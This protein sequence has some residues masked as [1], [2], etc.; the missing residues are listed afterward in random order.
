MTTPESQSEK[1]FNWVATGAIAGLV[2][3][4][5]GSHFADEVKEARDRAIT[6]QVMQ[7]RDQ[8]LDHYHIAHKPY[9][10]QNPKSE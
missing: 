7:A 1:Y 10:P 6:N 2:A 5:V 9:D 3:M 4:V 8:I